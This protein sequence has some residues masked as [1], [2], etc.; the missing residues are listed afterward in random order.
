MRQNGDGSYLLSPTDLVRFLGCHHAALLELK[1]LSEGLVWDESSE[2]DDLLRRTGLAHETK[3]LQLLKDE[4]KR[5]VEIDETLSSCERRDRTI[6]AMKEGCDVVYQ[7]ALFDGCWGGYADFIV[8]TPRPSRLGDYS[9]EAID[10]KLALRPEV[11]HLIQLSIYS[12]ALTGLNPVQ[13]RRPYFSRAKRSVPFGF[14]GV[15]G[16]VGV[17]VRFVLEVK[18]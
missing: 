4:G 13:T 17:S 15:N 7:A 12:D 5:V 6:A 10:T 16:V 18:V 9:Y 11:S 14:T 1:S 2:S 8:R 3:H